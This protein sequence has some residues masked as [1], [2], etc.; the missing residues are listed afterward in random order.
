M[1]MDGMDMTPVPSSMDTGSVALVLRLVLLLATAVVAGTGLL[2]PLVRHETRRMVAVVVSAGGLVLLTNVLEIV[3]LPVSVPLAVAHVVLTLALGLLLRWAKLAVW[4]GAALT[5]LLV[6]ESSTGHSGTEFAIGTVYVLGAV[7]WFGMTVLAA[8]TGQQTWHTGRVPPRVVAW[9]AAAALSLAG[10]LQSLVSGIG[11]DRRLYHTAFGVTLLLAVLLPIAL[12]ALVALLPRFSTGRR[13]YPAGVALVALAFLSWSAWGDLPQ[14]PALP[15]PGVPLLDQVSLAGKQHAILVSPQRAGINLVHF[16]DSAGRNLSVAAGS[17]PPV[18][19]TAR[20]GNDGTWAEVTLP[21]GRSDLVISGTQG[22]DTIEVDAGSAPGPAS[23]TGPDGPECAS[24]ALGGLVGGTRDV[25]AT[26]PSDAL[27]PAD[28]D[29]L[30]KLVGFLASRSAPAITV[31]G[32]GSPRSLQAEQVVRD[33]AAQAR[34]PVSDSPNPDSALVL[35][36]GWSDAATRL[37]AIAE[38]QATQRTYG[39]GIYLAPWLAHAPVVNSALTSFLPLPFN[40]RDDQ[41]LGY[42]VALAGS[43]DGE[44]PSTAG[45]QRW[46]A[47][48]RSSLDRDVAL[49]AAAQ[50]SA[51]PSETAEMAGMDMGMGGGNYPGQ[52]LPGG[53]IVPITAALPN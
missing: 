29:A 52:W 38:Q 18:R 24:A 22:Q 48:H 25:L 42:T 11:F 17:G 31:A 41:A 37:H 43:F 35:V 2:R 30:G 16:S 10:V 20:P 32:D 14:P 40:P 3:L 50:V 51:M 45:F 39:A 27:A 1:D 15:K 8:T 53:T 36:S 49:Y 13:M 44:T 6:V 47:A 12:T 28:A 7:V 26:C 19:A 46:L 5:V 9:T 33:R 23:A 21:P 34:I 4:G